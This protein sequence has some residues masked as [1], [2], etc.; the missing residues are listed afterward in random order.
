MQKSLAG[1]A[2]LLAATALAVPAHAQA[3][4]Y[5]TRPA[6]LVLAFGTGGSADVIG[7]LLATKVSEIWGHTLIVENKPGADGDLAAET[8]ARATP[9]GYTMLLTSQAL[10]V[11]VSLRPKRS[12]KV[13]DLAPIMLV[14]ETQTALTVPVAFEVKSVM[15]LI[16][17][18]KA[19]PG[20]LD[21]GSTGV[22]TSGHMAMELFRLTAGID[23][24]HVPFKNT[25]QWFTDMIAGRIKVGMPTIPGIT[26]HI[27]AGRLRA[28]GVAGTRRSPALPDT[29]TISEA[30]LTGYSTSTW[31]PLLTTKGAP[32][33]IV[34]RI[35]ATFQQALADTT[36]K[37]RFDDL[38]VE[39][40]GSSPAQLATHLSSEIARWAKGVK[41]AKISTE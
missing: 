38:G 8:V 33:A 32:E 18:A 30:G 15:E 5:P 6:K 25:G 7:R 13:E 10:A 41:E 40:V 12:Y 31:Y 21:Y 24:V 36:I 26:T 35:N 28:L 1:L 14:A 17:H 20:K 4:A 22:G 29:P 39:T 2:A 3:P 34:T 16:A 9:D 23:M 37:A 19:N 27:R 11:N